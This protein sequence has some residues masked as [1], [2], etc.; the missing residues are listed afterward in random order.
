[1]SNKI[2]G[3]KAPP[4]ARFDRADKFKSD[5]KEASD[6]TALPGG[7]FLVVS[8]SSDKVSLIDKNG[9]I[10]KFE[11]PDMPKL[12]LLEGVAYDPASMKLYVAREEKG[13]IW[14]YSW[15]PSKKDAP[16]LEQKRHL[17][18]DGPNNKGLEG[19]AFLSDAQSPT[20]KAT[21]VALKEGSPREM[22][23]LG[24]DGQSKPVKVDLEEQIKDV[25]A[26]FSAAAVDPKTGHI[27][28]SSDESSTVAEIKLKMDG[29]K[30]RGELV[31]SFPVRNKDDKP[32]GRIEG[33]SFNDKGDLM[34][35]TENDGE[36]HRLERK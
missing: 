29:N 7:K 30:V 34:V 32:L 36:L 20:G 17:K 18:F 28:I 22:L 15:D 21:L 4:P 9:K 25:C 31:Q 10:S 3:N 35:L 14:S 26:D 6:V 23:L 8:D 13:D 1:M 5:V 12:S 27:F 2:S 33:L 11:L 16:K 24:K 19:L